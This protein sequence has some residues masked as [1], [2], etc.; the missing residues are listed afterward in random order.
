MW[1]DIIKVIGEV[2]N[3]LIKSNKQQDLK[4]GELMLEIHHVLNDVID[5]FEKGEYP[6]LS[7]STMNVLTTNLYEKIKPSLKDKSESVYLLLME[8]SNLERS[9]YERNST[10]II[11]ELKKASGEFKGLSILLKN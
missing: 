10:D 9:F 8:A 3:H 5:K 6:H 1:L 4:M 7:C 11:S 2:I